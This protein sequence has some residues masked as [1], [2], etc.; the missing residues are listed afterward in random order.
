MFMV[1]NSFVVFILFY[2]MLG[3]WAEKVGYHHVR[4]FWIYNILFGLFQAPYYAYVQT[5]MSEVTQR[6]Y[7]NMFFGLF[8]IT[9]GAVSHCF[10]NVS[11]SNIDH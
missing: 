6:G 7:E 3:L 1:T 8:G 10:D 9:N 5:M 4:D 11:L 2:G